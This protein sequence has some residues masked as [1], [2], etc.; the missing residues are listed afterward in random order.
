[1]GLRL[2]VLV[3][4]VV[5]S[6]AGVQPQLRV[7]VVLLAAAGDYPGETYTTGPAAPAEFV[8][9][10][11]EPIAID[12]SLANW[13][14][15]T[16]SIVLPGPPD[17]PD[18]PVGAAVW[19]DGAVQAEARLLATV[20][21]DTIAETRPVE[22]RPTMAIAPGD[23]V[24]WRL[25]V[26]TAALTPGFYEALTRTA[27]TAVTVDGRAPVRPE[28]AGFT[29]ELRPRSAAVPEE[30]LRRD[31]EWL[32]ATGDPV[33]A[34]A[35][36]AALERLYP[37]SVVVHLIRSRIAEAEGNDRLARQELDRAA[38]FMRADRDRLFRRFA[39]PGQIEDLIDSL[40][41]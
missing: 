41:P 28:R 31:A 14:T 16:A 33:S 24:R 8:F 35:A 1:V 21:R 30:L 23:A 11:G 18:V 20:W 2:V 39:R 22:P 27:V 34:R 13:G 37:D 6:A 17:V 3:L 9:F 5:S 29:L 7:P 4:A 12:I 15:G 10:V 25:M 19:R 36:V 32:T 26:D 38:A 40:R